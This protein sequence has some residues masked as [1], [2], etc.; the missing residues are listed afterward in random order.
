MLDGEVDVEIPANAAETV[1]RTG[2]DLE[3]WC[4]ATSRP[5]RQLGGLYH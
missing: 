5:S 3:P 2:A 4:V 1:A